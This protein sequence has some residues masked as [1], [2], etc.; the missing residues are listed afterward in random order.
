MNLNK[1]IPAHGLD[2]IQNINH[3]LEKITPVL[4][5]FNTFVKSDITT[6]LTRALHG[7]LHDHALQIQVKKSDFI[8]KISSFAKK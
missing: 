3:K 1:E 4:R 7:P 6:K 5:W 2:N 8:I